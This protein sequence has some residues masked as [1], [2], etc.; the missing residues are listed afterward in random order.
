MEKKEFNR[1][2]TI[3][4]ITNAGLKEYPTLEIKSPLD[5]FIREKERASLP[6]E[7]LKQNRFSALKCIIGVGD[8]VEGEVVSKC[9]FLFTKYYIGKMQV[10]N[11]M[12]EKDTQ[13]MQEVYNEVSETIKEYLAIEAA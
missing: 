8:L 10:L 13:Y 3:V 5:F 2:K 6:F 9:E 4:I 11:K 7:L 1:E 12:T